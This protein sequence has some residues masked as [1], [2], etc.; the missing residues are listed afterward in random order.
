MLTS[1]IPY[2]QDYFSR[3]WAIVPVAAMSKKAA[4]EWKNGSYRSYI[5]AQAAIDACTNLNIGIA[6]GARSGNLIDID[7]DSPIAEKIAYLF[8]PDTRTFGHGTRPI[9]HR[10]YYTDESCDIQL[11]Y[12]VGT[13]GRGNKGKKLIE[14]RANGCM[15]VFPGSIHESGE[16]IEWRNPDTEIATIKQETLKTRLGQLHAAT[17]FAMRTEDGTRHD[18]AMAIGGWLARAGYP[19]DD[20]ILI[21]R[22]IAKARA[23]GGESD[24]EQAVRDSYRRYE[25]GDTVYGKTTLDDIYGAS[26]VRLAAASLGISA[27]ARKRKTLP[28]FPAIEGITDTGYDCNDTGNAR[29]FCALYGGDIRYR[30]KRDQWLVWGDEGWRVDET[31]AMQRLA[32]NAI[33]RIKAESAA[34]TGDRRHDLAEWA[35]N[36]GNMPRRNALIEAVKHVRGISVVEDD[37]DQ[38]HSLLKLRNATINLESGIVYPHERNDLLV[39]QTAITY[40]ESAECPEWHAFLE[41]IIPSQAV[42]DFLQRAVGYSLTGYTREHLFFLLYGIGANGKSTFLKVL[43]GLLGESAVATQMATLTTKIKAGGHSDEIAS[44]SG[45]RIVT[46]SEAP[47]SVKWNAGIVKQLVSEDMVRASFKGEHGFDFT[48]TH[49]LWLALNH[50]P[51]S[52]D[53]SDGFWRRMSNIPFDVQIPEG[54]RDAKLIDRLLEELPGILNWAIAGAVMYHSEG[55]LIQPEEVKKETRDYRLDTDKVARWLE[56]CTILNPTNADTEYSR[57]LYQSFSNWLRMSGEQEESERWFAQ[58]LKAK[59]YT[60]EKNRNGMLLYGIKLTEMQQDIV[61]A[62]EDNNTQDVCLPKRPPYPTVNDLY[63]KIY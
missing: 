28:D 58:R 25:E 12:D 22:A 55:R 37:I 23:K 56:D 54:E 53:D 48:P 44:L 17:L 40:T 20:A 62:V 36:S 41:R 52:E 59:G 9:S 35:I 6:L 13:K 24:S 31:G 4:V 7:F 29:R 34:A 38:R 43:A 3:E 60:K 45:A 5:S 32:V 19:L 49:K 51:D 42:R 27:A 50:R 16:P 11:Y 18:G 14:L 57:T 61:N 46:I 10:I 15:T 2:V 26:V 30:V 1:S 63:R 21:V 8:L 39:K 47:E 33:E